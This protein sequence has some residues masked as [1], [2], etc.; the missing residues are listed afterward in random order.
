MRGAKKKSEYTICVY[1]NE[2]GEEEPKEEKIEILYDRRLQTLL[3]TAERDNKKREL[4]K[5]RN[6]KLD[7]TDIFPVMTY[8]PDCQTKISIDY[9]G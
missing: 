5:D 3:I 6:V 4:R 8:I 7:Q 2:A 1:K 9:Q